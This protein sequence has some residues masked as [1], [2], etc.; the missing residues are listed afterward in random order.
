MIMLNYNMVKRVHAAKGY[1][2][3]DT[4]DFNLNIGFVRESNTFTDKLT[5]TFYIAYREL[6]VKRSFIAH[7]TT[8]AGISPA[9][10]NPKVVAGMKGVAVVKPGQY[11]GCWR[12]VDSYLGWLKYP[13]L[14]QVKPI[15]V[16]RDANADNTID[17]N[18]EQEGLLGIN[19]HRMSG[20]GMVGG[21]LGNWSEGCMGM[22]EPNWRTALPILRESVKNYGD[23]FTLTLLELA[24]IK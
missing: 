14:Q 21:I 16:Y 18:Q 10:L 24:D 9:L 15:T 11:R 22:D 1:A 5:D 3:Y 19:V 17:T 23:I 2:F 7:A 20:I 12:L 4:G 6:G 8:K 13:Y